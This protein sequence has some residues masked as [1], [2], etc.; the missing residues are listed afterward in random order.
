VNP[1]AKTAL[2]VLC[3]GAIT[4]AFLL[5]LWVAMRRP[6]TRHRKRSK[7]EPYVPAYGAH[8]DWHPKQEFPAP[9]P[10]DAHLDVYEQERIEEA[11]VVAAVERL[12][13]ARANRLRFEMEADAAKLRAVETDTI[14]KIRYVNFDPKEATQEIS[15][16]PEMA[17]KR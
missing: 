16:S 14:K 3:A 12:E 4:A 13:A 1:V 10:L 7:R 2:L 11:N 6:Q 17:G 9:R 15:W 8:E 5:L